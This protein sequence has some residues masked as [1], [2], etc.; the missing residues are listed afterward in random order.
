[1]EFHKDLGDHIRTT[2]AVIQIQG[3]GHVFV[4]YDGAA[5]G[6]GIAGGGGSGI[7]EILERNRT[8]SCIGIYGVNVGAELQILQLK[9]YLEDLGIGGLKLQRANGSNGIIGLTEDEST[10]DTAAVAALGD[11]R[12]CDLGT[13]STEGVV[14]GLVCIIGE[15]E[16]YT[17]TL[18]DVGGSHDTVR[19][20]VCPGIDG[21]LCVSLVVLRIIAEAEIQH[22]LILGGGVI[23][24][25][26]FFF[27][28]EG[29]VDGLLLTELLGRQD[30]LGGE[31]LASEGDIGAGVS[32]ATVV[33]IGHGEHGEG[34]TGNIT[35]V[36]YGVEAIVVHVAGNHEGNTHLVENVGPFFKDRFHSAVGVGGEG[37][38]A[39]HDTGVVILPLAL[40]V[41]LL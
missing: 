9:A 39:D 37:E 7:L 16:V 34:G 32:I 36:S 26:L 6:V 10:G 20:I 31:G 19:V 25:Q 21:I 38:V 8:F 18:D 41:D 11:V 22:I 30:I 12:A 2:E 1:M 24:Q 27:C 28:I 14:E 33:Q 29:V 4:R 13:G 5:I 23:G 17:A 15:V 3:H 35:A 40:G